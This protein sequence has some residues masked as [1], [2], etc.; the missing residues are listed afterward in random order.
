MNRQDKKQAMKIRKT[1]DADLNEILH[2]E[3]EAFNSE[4]EP[5]LT[6]EILEDPSAKPVLSLIAL[7]E[8]QP[9][10]HILFS[11]AHILGNLDLAVYFLA[12]LAVISKFQRQGVG[13]SLIKKGL[14]LLEKSGVDLV[15]VVGHPTYYPRYGF[16]PARKIGFEPT[17]PMPK[18]VADAWMVQ[19][20]KPGLIGSVSGKVVCCDALNKPGLWRE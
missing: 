18:E 8:D 16:T 7:I 9:A 15:F 5:A 6:K 14:V 2:V 17:Y 11:K 10:G 1:T 12:P 19:V 3:R 20:L 4:K 13:G